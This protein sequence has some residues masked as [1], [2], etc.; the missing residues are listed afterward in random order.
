[1][2]RRF[3]I[4]MTTPSNA[5]PAAAVPVV[6]PE[7]APT[8]FLSFRNVPFWFGLALVACVVGLIAQ[9]R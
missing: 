2:R 4:S 1:M 7:F 5:S 9:H 6:A 3:E 8:P